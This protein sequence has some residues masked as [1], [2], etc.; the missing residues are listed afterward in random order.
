[1]HG[2]GE[3]EEEEEGRRGNGG[4]EAIGSG[5]RPGERELLQASF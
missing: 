1:M 2:Q 5:E 3:E 4:S